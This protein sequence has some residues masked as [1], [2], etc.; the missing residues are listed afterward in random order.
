MSSFLVVSGSLIL[1]LAVNHRKRVT[2]VIKR[3]LS[4]V[5]RF[6]LCHVLIFWCQKFSVESL[7]LV[8]IC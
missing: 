2:L 7:P 1:I 3:F 8:N 5:L 6:I 4:I